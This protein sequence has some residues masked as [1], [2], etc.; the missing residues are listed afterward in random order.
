MKITTNLKT[1]QNVNLVTS[2]GVKYIKKAISFR[3]KEFYQIIRDKYH[4]LDN[5]I[6]IPEIVE[7]QNAYFRFIEEGQVDKRS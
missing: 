7:E 5:I 3:E 2:H 1:Y 6:L 4:Q